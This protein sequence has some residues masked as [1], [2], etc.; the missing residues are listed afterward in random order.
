MA[1][2]GGQGAAPAGANGG[3]AEE[4][5][6]LR[7]LVEQQE[8]LLRLVHETSDSWVAAGTPNVKLQLMV[9]EQRSAARGLNRQAAS[10]N[11]DCSVSLHNLQ[12]VLRQ[13]WS[14]YLESDPSY[15]P[16]MAYDDYRR[17]I[18][19]KS[20]NCRHAMNTLCPLVTSSGVAPPRFPATIQ[21]FLC[22]STE[23]IDA[24]LEAYDMPTEGFTV[25]QRSQLF[26]EFVTAQAQLTVPRRPAS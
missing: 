24:L 9:Q 21:D 20:P 22:M 23:E 7:A 6:Q 8:S 26:A 12:L 18:V 17:Q 10:S 13:S 1:G 16:A 3:L 19:F 4:V 2:A 25:E 5:K 15:G 14:A 11:Y